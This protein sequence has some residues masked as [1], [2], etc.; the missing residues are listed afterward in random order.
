V[1]ANVSSSSGRG[2]PSVLEAK[3][4]L[5][6]TS[7]CMKDAGRHCSTCDDDDDDDDGGDDDDDDDDGDGDGDAVKDD[8]DAADY[9][10]VLIGRRSN[11]T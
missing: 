2:M 9:R 7:I 5:C 3:E 6:S 4:G 8:D 11:P 1:I 10:V